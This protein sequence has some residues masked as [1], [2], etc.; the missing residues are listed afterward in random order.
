MMAAQ[1]E[2]ETSSAGRQ[3]RDARAG[4]D[5][6]AGAWVPTRPRM[7]PRMAPRMRRLDSARLLA[8]F[9]IL[10]CQ[11]GGPGLRT[12]RDAGLAFF[13]MGLVLLGLP[14]ATQGAQIGGNSR[15]PGPA[16][17]AAVARLVRDL[18]RAKAGRTGAQRARAGRRRAAGARPAAVVCALCLCPLPA[19]CAGRPASCG[20]LRA[21]PKSADP[22]PCGHCGRRRAAGA[23]CPAAVVCARGLCPAAGGCRA[24]AP[25]CCGRLRR[26]ACGAVCG[27]RLDAP[28]GASLGGASLGA[29]RGGLS[30]RAGP[31]AGPPAVKLP[32]FVPLG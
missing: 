30:V 31:C 25:L 17:V 7:G 4:L 9:G 27:V 21:G 15:Q 2:G 14:A 1:P 12:I 28:R 10:V 32:S 18:W 8:A 29:N 6:E 3:N 26:G 19:V 5:L 13:V 11:A 23:P 24:R 22:R 20:G 16:A